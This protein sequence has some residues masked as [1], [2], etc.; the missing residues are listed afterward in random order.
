MFQE[1]LGEIKDHLF[2][3]DHSNHE[4]ATIFDITNKRTEAQEG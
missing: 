1:L 3:L 2:R 4:A